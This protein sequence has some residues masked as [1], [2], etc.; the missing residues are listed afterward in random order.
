LRTGLIMGQ[1]KLKTTAISMY[2]ERNG[3]NIKVSHCSNMCWMSLMNNTKKYYLVGKLP[4]CDLKKLIH[5]HV[6]GNTQHM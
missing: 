6:E 4:P 5:Y 3:D 1:L 2:K